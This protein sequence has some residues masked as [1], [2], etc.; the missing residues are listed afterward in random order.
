MGQGRL[1]L[2]IAS[3][4]ALVA[5]LERRPALAAD[6]IADPD[7]TLLR[8]AGI[9]TD[10][11]SLTAFLH[12]Q[13]ASNADFQNLNS[14]I[15]QLG[16]ESFAEREQA[17]KKLVALGA[18]A[19]YRLQPTVVDPD[20]EVRRR[21]KAC[22]SQIASTVNL[23]LQSAAV[24]L[25]VRRGSPGA[26]T[27]LLHYLPSAPNEETIED[28][29]FGLDALAVV[30]GRVNP[31]LVAALH[32]PMPP[33]RAAAACIVARVGD[34]KQRA[35]VRNL[36]KDPDPLVRLRAAQGLLCIK[37]PTALPVLIA[38]LGEPSV[39]LSWQAEELLHWVAGE[40]APMV[41]LGAAAADARE[42]CRTAW[43]AWWRDWN[44][45]RDWSELDGRKR[46]PGLMLVCETQ[47]VPRGCPG[48]VWLS[49]CDG[50][51]RWLL[52]DLQEPIDVQLLPG[53]RLLLAE[54]SQPHLPQRITERDLEGRILWQV[55]VADSGGY[56]AV[57]A[58]RLANGNTFIAFDRAL[59][60]VSADGKERYFHKYPL[61]LLPIYA[62]QKLSHSRILC[63]ANLD[64]RDNAAVTE[65]DTATRKEVKRIPLLQGISNRCHIEALAGKHYLLSSPGDCRVWEV[66]ATGA[67]VWQLGQR[68]L[69]SATRLR[70]GT[71]LAIG[72]EQ[73]TGY[74][75]AMMRGHYRILR[76]GWTNRSRF[77]T[78]TRLH[79]VPNVS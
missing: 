46:Q 61:K 72:W 10:A 35:L 36:L 24:R 28:V 48:R 51:P 37:D 47:R 40:R 19:A 18:P 42:K 78:T 74:R 79:L 45:K 56:S 6:E 70:S 53:N 5:I 16:S 21:A 44:T 1:L 73:G 67:T 38:L 71:T 14:L 76:G 11:A 20:P 50:R 64:N 3:L 17:A 54:A 12:K 66:D 63:V 2:G 33:R 57:A 8:E 31:P 58:K 59:L 41:T 34:S 7:E 52:Q 49:G 62:A 25:I 22:L 60:E 69:G 39:G 29:V 32:D 9:G 4:L 55:P 23:D 27:A 65:Y 75:S 26:V 13:S 68:R 15:R 77:L 43:E 30:Q